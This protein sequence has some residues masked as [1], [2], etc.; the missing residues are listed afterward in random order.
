MRDAWYRFLLVWYRL[1]GHSKVQAEWRAR[2]ALE[3]P[4]AVR[5]AVADTHARTVDAR[6]TCVCGQLLVRGDEVCHACGRRQWMP[7]RLRQAL[8]WLGV[9][10][11]PPTAGTFMMVALIVIAHLA[12]LRY[13]HGT[14]ASPWAGYLTMLDLGGSFG[15]IDRL[16]PWRVFTYTL[17]HG[18]FMHLL[19]NGIALLQIGP[20]VERMFGTAR[21]VLGYVVAGA[22][23]VLIPPLVG[24]THE[25]GGVFVPVVGASGA[26]SG[27]LGMAA[28]RGHLAGTSQGKAIR[29]FCIKWMVYVTIFGVMMSAGRGGGVAHDAH[30]AGFAGGILFGWLV[31]PEDQRATRRRLTPLFGLLGVAAIAAAMVGQLTWLSAGARPAPSGDVMEAFWYEKLADVRGLEAALGPEA[32]SLVR[33]GQELARQGGPRG[34]YDQRVNAFLLTLRPAQV[35]VMVLELQ[36][37]AMRH[38]ADRPMDEP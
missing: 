37:V 11:L 38:H 29:D 23:A 16:Q 28:I 32:A 36:G 9:S 18:G 21:F 24:F 5:E 17:V 15:P 13:E 2:R 34:D 6:F 12:R 19:F 3:A 7:A 14:Q 30:F 26:I 10:N 4:R 22:A 20:A 1:L 27:L 8:R 31:P 33:E 35:H 25:M